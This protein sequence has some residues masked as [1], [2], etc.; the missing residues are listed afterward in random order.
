MFFKSCFVCF[1]LC[2]FWFK[3]GA[4]INKIIHIFIEYSD[5]EVL[6]VLHGF[7]LS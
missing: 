4:R 1:A 2:V 6:A 7:V 3:L 5:I